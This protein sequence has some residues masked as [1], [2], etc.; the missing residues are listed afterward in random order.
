MLDKECKEALIH[1]GNPNAM[2]FSG[3]KSKKYIYEAKEHFAI[4]S[5]SSL[6][7]IK[8]VPSASFAIFFAIKSASK[9]YSGNIACLSTDHSAVIN[10]A[11]E[12]SVEMNRSCVYLDVNDDGLLER[13]NLMDAILNKG[14]K[15]LALCSVNNETGIIQDIDMIL[16][17]ARSNQVVV[18]VDSV[19][20]FGKCD[21]KYSLPNSDVVILSGYKFGG[22]LG[23]SCCIMRNE[24]LLKIFNENIQYVT[25]TPNYLAIHSMFVAAKNI[26]DDYE[27]EKKAR[28]KFELAISKMKG[29]EIIGKKSMRSIGISSVYFENALASEILV[30]LDQ[31]GVEASIGAA[32]SSIGS[33]GSRVIRAILGEDKSEKVIRFSFCGNEDIDMDYLIN[34]VFNAYEKCRWSS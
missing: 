28:D 11:K 20:A 34:S 14:V 23:A 10:S 3:R 1:S 30:I 25:G 33:R 15:I 27:K 32:C 29:I 8:F 22:L 19:A 31:M 4:L 7:N 17:V 21:S 13:E 24:E 12:V 2:H 5:K 18:I 26:K 16:E 9:I 6:H